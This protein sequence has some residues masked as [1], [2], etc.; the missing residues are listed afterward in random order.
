MKPGLT[1]LVLMA[2]L[3]S[4]ASVACGPGIIEDSAVVAEDADIPDTPE[5]REIVYL[6]EVYRRA[7]EDKDVASLRNLV[8]SDYYENSGTTHTTHDDYGYNGLL[9]VFEVYAE[10]VRQ[11]RLQVLIHSIEISG[12]RANVYVD[13]GFNMHY[14]VNGQERWQVDRGLNR[15]ELVWEQEQWRILAGL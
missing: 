9:E 4:L 12:D 14:V 3:S 5:F 2:L 7:I 15:I 1:T 6:V 8:S 13:F 11:I 10:S